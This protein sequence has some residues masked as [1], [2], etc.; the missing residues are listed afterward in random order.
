MS[1]PSTPT[2]NMNRAV[3]AFLD[4]RRLKGYLFNFSALRES[5]H[6]FP[7]DRVQKEGG[8]DVQMKDLKAVFFVKDFKGNPENKEPASE[9]S[10]QHGRKIEITFTDGEKLT[11]TTEGYNPQKLGFFVFPGDARSNNVRVFVVNKN[12]R[13]VKML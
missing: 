2:N 11:G 1:S 6:L 13:Q 8:T 3:V 4:G 12:V 10:Q 5:F 7:D 9:I